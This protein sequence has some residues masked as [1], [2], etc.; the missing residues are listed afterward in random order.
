[1]QNLSHRF[2]MLDKVKV[3]GVPVLYEQLSID[4]IILFISCLS[5]TKLACIM[6]LLILI[7]FTCLDTESEL[8]VWD[9]G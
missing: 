5:L 1:M 6:H 8:S 3:F 7:H 2:R 9:A 4:G